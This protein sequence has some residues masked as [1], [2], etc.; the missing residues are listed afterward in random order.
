MSVNFV[1]LG[2]IRDRLTRE[3]VTQTGA[4][5]GEFFTHRDPVLLL[6]IRDTG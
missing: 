6:I 1:S 5:L 2:I 3:N 4:G